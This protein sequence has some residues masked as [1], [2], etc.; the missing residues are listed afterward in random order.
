MDGLTGSL[1]K[2]SSDIVDS[3]CS[4]V[5]RDDV[6]ADNTVDIDRDIVLGLDHLSGNTSQ[7]DLDICPSVLLDDLAV[8]WVTYQRLG[9]FQSRH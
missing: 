5:R 9:W 7:L 8:L 3:E 4:S 2:C 6:P 1:D